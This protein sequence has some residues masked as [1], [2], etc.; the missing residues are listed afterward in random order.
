[1]PPLELSR[2]LLSGLLLQRFH[3]FLAR[4][5]DP[6]HRLPGYAEFS[7]FH[8][9]FLYESLWSLLAFLVLI[10]LATHYRK[11]IRPG[12]LTALYLIFYAAGRT[13]VELVR[14]DSRVITIG[15]VELQI[16]VAT[17]VSLGVALLM[18]L[19]IVWGRM[20]RTGDNEKE[21]GS[22]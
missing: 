18:A 15:G 14:L 22:S 9:A 17:L 7:R 12:E 19:W 10:T 1:M 8:P 13:L 21:A 11:R 3:F 2:G 16:A 20:R 5:I 6:V 4:T